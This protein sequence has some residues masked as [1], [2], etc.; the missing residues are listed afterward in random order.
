MPRT[1]TDVA[2]E[3]RGWVVPDALWKKIKPLLPALPAPNP[4][5]GQQW[6]PHRKAMNGIFFVLKT[7][8]QWNALNETGICSS[9]T[10]HRR[11][12]E[13]TELGVFKGLWEKRLTDYDERK[14]IQWRWQSVD[15]AMTK[16]PLGG[17]KI[18][19]SPTDRAKL[20]VKR[21]LL[22]DG[23]GVVIGLAVDGANRHDMK[24]LEA[25]QESIPS[26]R[27][28]SG[29]AARRPRRSRSGLGSR[30]GAGSWSARAAG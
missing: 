16:A 9:S 7:G 24:L 8:C 21:S 12:Q 19:P 29:R 3:S 13:W 25:T 10:A 1:R 6:V 28:I 5:G 30:H 4:K 18:G 23:R 17:E 11:F 26:T 2:V 27:L 14:G 15:G 20:G 22:C